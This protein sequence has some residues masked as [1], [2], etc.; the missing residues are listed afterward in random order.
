MLLKK[1]SPSVP[2]SPPPKIPSPNNLPENGNEI[3]I[4]EIKQASSLA[5]A[6][7]VA[8]KIIRKLFTEYENVKI[9]DLEAIKDKYEKEQERISYTQ[10]QN[11]LPSL[12]ET[13]P[14][15]RGIY[16]QV[17]QDVARRVKKAFRGFF[18][19]LKSKTGE[20]GYPRFKSFGRYDSFTYSQNNNSYKLEQ[21]QLRLASIGKVKIKLHR[22]LEG[23]VKTCSIIV[24]NGKY[25]ACFSS[26]V[27]PKLLPKTGKKVG[28]DLGLT[29]F[30]ATSDGE[31]KEAPKTYRKAEK[32][33]AKAGRKVSRRIKRSKRRKKAVILLAK[34]HEKVSNQRKDLAHKLA[35]ELVEKYDGIAYEKLAIKNMGIEVN[36]KN[37]SQICSECDKQREQKLK[38]SQR[39][40]AC[41]FC[42]YSDNRDINAARNILKRTEWVGSTLQGA[43]PAA[44]Q[45]KPGQKTTFLE[46]NAMKFCK[47]FNQ[48]T[49]ELESS[50]ILNVRIIISENKD[51]QFAIQGQITSNLIK[52]VGSEKKTLSAEEIEKIA[53]EKLPYLNTTDIEKAKKIVAGSVRSFKDFKIN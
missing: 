19:R 10:Q 4:S 50:K 51:Y 52:K 2:F 30:L 3:D 34:Q 29:S 11:S 37:T 21:S 18:L 24:K 44:G 32:E 9:E 48:Q 12:K 36:A 46:K 16:S 6:K 53:Q 7:K 41:S 35:K 25:Y 8:K 40:F 14:N 42:P 22:E 5:E 33:L 31:L 17:L 47:E 43:V 20:A 45:A 27:E 23:E 13:N 26:E 28:I 39:K 1:A 15:L 49:K 38:L